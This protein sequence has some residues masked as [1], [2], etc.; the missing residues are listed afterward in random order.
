MEEEVCAK[1]K[2]AKEYLKLQET[3]NE[4]TKKVFS[5]FAKRLE[6]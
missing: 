5:S 4:Q 6:S 3:S 1:S 2:E